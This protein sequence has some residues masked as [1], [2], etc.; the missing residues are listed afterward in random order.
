M[1]KKKKALII[2]LLVILFAILFYCISWL[3]YYNSVCKPHITTELSY[4][5]DEVATRYKCYVSEPDE[6]YN[7]YFIFVPKFGNFTCYCSARSSV[8]IDKTDFIENPDGSIEYSNTYN[9]SGAAFDYSMIAEFQFNGEIKCYKFNVTSNSDDDKYAQAAFLMLNESG[10]LLNEDSLTD[11]ELEIFK[12][13][14]NDLV[15]IIKNAN[16]TFMIK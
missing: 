2:V 14:Y 10:D 3:Y 8:G 12:D 5:E 1:Q 7:R 16:K 4:Q 6:N 9:M 15:D 11:K 13:S